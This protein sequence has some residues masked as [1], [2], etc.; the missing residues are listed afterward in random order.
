MSGLSTIAFRVALLMALGLHATEADIAVVTVNQTVTSTVP[1]HFLSVNM[2]WHLYDEEWPAWGTASVLNIDFTNERFIKL[3]TALAPALWRIGG[4]E[5]DMVVYA[6]SSNDS[7]CANTSFCLNLTRWTQIDEFA[8]TTGLQI[9]FGLNGMYGRTTPTTPLD[10]SNIAWFLAQLAAQSSSAL[11]GFELGNELT[12]KA[13]PTTIGHD[14]IAVRALIDKYWPDASSRPKLI[15]PDL[16]PDQ[17]YLATFLSIANQTL[18][19]VTYHL[20]IGYG[21]NPNL[22]QQLR[23]PAF[24]DQDWQT[25]LP[26]AATVAQHAPHAELWVGE[27]AAAWHSGQA[28]TT[29]AFISSLW[30]IDQSSQLAAHGHKAFCRQTLVGG[31]YGLLNWT[32]FEPN[33]DYFTALLFK[34]LMGGRVLPTSVAASS[35]QLRAYAQCSGLTSGGVTVAIINLSDSVAF[36]TA[37]EGFDVGPKRNE[38]ALTADGWNA[39][40]MQLKGMPLSCIVNA[41]Q[42]SAACRHCFLRRCPTSSRCWWHLAAH[43]SSNFLAR[44]R[45]C[46]P[47]RASEKL[48][49][50]AKF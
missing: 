28:N 7:I 11:Y 2:D 21:L 3:T 45:L 46:A 47:E 12:T 16:N 44:L 25:G 17:P 36:T 26:L 43:S 14:Y 49:R 39:L 38:Y 5:G 23:D 27:S 8:D 30:Y 10:T 29:D 13:D 50:P 4:S 37:F 15:G 22:T 34:R 1:A 6:A 41:F 33:P 9:V 19:A 32:N 48:R 18:D 42:P 20:Y 40:T 24:L 31:W 35:P